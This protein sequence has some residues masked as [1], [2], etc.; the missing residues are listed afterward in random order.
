MPYNARHKW[1]AGSS[2]GVD[3]KDTAATTD[4]ISS[5]PQDNARPSSCHCYALECITGL[6]LSWQADL[7]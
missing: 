5:K 1:R 3:F 6:A 4:Q 2:L 7:S